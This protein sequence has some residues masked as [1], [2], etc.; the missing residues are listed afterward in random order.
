MT[1]SSTYAAP[2]DAANAAA[3]ARGG[4]AKAATATN[5]LSKLAGNFDDFLSLLTT[6]LK[7]Q[8][9]TSPMDTNQFTSQLVQFTAVSEQISTNATLSQLLA[10]SLAQQLGQAS[11]LIGTEVS[12]SGGVL[13][14]QKGLAQADFQSGGAQPVQISVYDAN[15]SPVHSETLDAV[16]GSNSWTWDGTG[17]HGEQLP[18]GAYGIAVTAAGTALDVRAVGTVTGAEQ[19]NQ[20]VQLRFGAASVGYDKVVSLGRASF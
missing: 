10:A 17:S 11:G 2:I 9:P 13:P 19:S 1:I 18:D 14:L 16:D 8:D 20:A 12:V 7:N 3:A 5:T 4:G 6:Q 15:G